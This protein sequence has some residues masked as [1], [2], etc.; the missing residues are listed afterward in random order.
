MITAPAFSTPLSSAF[1]IIALATRY[2]PLDAYMLRLVSAV[3]VGITLA[4]PAVK[5][6]FATARQKKEGAAND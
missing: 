4:M 6:N 2:S 1:S 5:R 3:I